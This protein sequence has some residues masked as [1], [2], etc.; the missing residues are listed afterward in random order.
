MAYLIKTLLK[1]YDFTFIKGEG[2]DFTKICCRLTLGNMR[3][4]S[5]TDW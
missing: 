1:I 5:A 4:K 2:I 3:G